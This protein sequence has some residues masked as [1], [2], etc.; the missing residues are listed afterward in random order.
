MLFTLR[1]MGHW[2]NCTWYRS[3]PDVDEFLKSCKFLAVLVDQRAGYVR[4][5]A[6]ATQAFVAILCKMITNEG[7]WQVSF[8]GAKVSPCLLILLS[9]GQRPLLQTNATVN[10]YRIMILS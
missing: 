6:M 1:D 3:C 5:L 8:A 4:Q 7:W 2:V 9:S 10:L